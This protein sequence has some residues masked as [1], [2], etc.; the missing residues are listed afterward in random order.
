MKGRLTLFVENYFQQRSL[1]RRNVPSL[2][3]GTLFPV[4]FLIIQRWFSV[5][6]SVLDESRFQ[7]LY[8]QNVYQIDDFALDEASWVIGELI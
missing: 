6:F 8:H 1:S 3:I 7:T 4:V 5:I 2:F